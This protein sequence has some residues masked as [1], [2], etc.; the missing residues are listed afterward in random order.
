MENV[1]LVTELT[2]EGLNF[3]WE[4]RVVLFCVT[5]LWYL[6]ILAGNIIII[7]AII[8]DKSLHEP[9]Y[10]FLCNLCINSLYGTVGF[11]PKFLFDLLNSHVISYAGC[12]LQGYVIHSSVCCDFSLLALMAL[13]RYVALC[14]PLIYHS[15]MTKRRVYVLVILSWIVPL[16]CMFMNT[17]TL[18]QT[19]LCGSH[20]N[21]LYCV[22]FMIVRLACSPPLASAYVSYFNIVFYFGHFVLIIWSYIYLIKTCLIGKKN[23]AKFMQT[24]VPHLISLSVSAFAVLLDLLYMR[25]GSPD[26]SQNLSNFMAMEILLI[27]PMLNPVVYGMK[28]TKIRIWILKIVHVHRI[29]ATCTSKQPVSNSGPDTTTTRKPRSQNSLETPFGYVTKAVAP[30][31]LICEIRCGKLLF[32]WRDVRSSWIGCFVQLLRDAL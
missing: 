26:L 21:R 9:M 29:D 17:A 28:L 3:P 20:I 4:Q 10:I 31:Y 23:W 25:L 8:L 22:N 27:P 32:C 14:R 11:Y 16:F 5:L 15:V 12:M 7:V 2:L 18:L 30:T 1:S 24:C 19:Q 6:M 13:D